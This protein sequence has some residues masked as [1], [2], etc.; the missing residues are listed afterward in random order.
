MKTSSPQNTNDLFPF[1]AHIIFALVLISTLA[2]KYPAKT[3]FVGKLIDR[4]H[5][6]FFDGSKKTGPQKSNR[7]HFT[8]AEIDS[9]RDPTPPPPPPK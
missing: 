8:V 5:S 4:L 1:A 9:S 2:F 7:L 6:F 3:D